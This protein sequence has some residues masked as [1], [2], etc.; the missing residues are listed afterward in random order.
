MSK[1]LSEKL[2]GH[3]YAF[4]V[5]KEAIKE[6]EKRGKGVS[7]RL[8]ILTKRDLI[9]IFGEKLINSEVKDGN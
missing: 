6:L 8:Y 7:G 1:T 5:I 3:P 9:E 2:K 4:R